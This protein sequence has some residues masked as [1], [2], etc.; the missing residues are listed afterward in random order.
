MRA[1]GEVVSEPD[2]RLRPAGPGASRHHPGESESGGDRSGDGS[3]IQGESIRRGSAALHPDRHQGQLQHL[4]HADDRRQR[5]HEEFAATQRRVYGCEDTQGGCTDPRQDEPFGVRARRHVA[6]QPWRPDEESL[7]PD[8]HARRFQRRYRRGPRRELRRSRDRQRHR[9]VDPLAGVRQ[10]SCRC[11]SD[12]RPGQ[13][14][15]RHPKQPD[16]G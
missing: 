8:P 9:P 16:A 1:T 14:E 5:R 2:R 11:T 15:R 7:R 3:A 10:Q 13:P 4:R 6:Q 12:A